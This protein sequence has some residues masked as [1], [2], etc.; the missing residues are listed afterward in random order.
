VLKALDELLSFGQF[1]KRVV[2]AFPELKKAEIGD[3]IR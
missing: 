2:H 1:R 3:A